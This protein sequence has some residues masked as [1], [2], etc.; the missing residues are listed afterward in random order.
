M[1]GAAMPMFGDD[2]AIPRRAEVVPR[3][4]RRGCEASLPIDRLLLPVIRSGVK[5]I[6]RIAA[7]AGGGK[8]TAIRHLR[9]VLPAGADVKLFD[10]HQLA[11]AQRAAC[12]GLA[13]F[14][15]S[16]P[17][18]DEK[19][20]D[21]FYLSP[22][23][24][25]DC[26]EYLHA[27][28][29]Q[30]CG[31]VLNRLC[32]EVSLATLAGLPQ[33]LCL[34][35]D[36]MCEDV[37]LGGAREILRQHIRRILPTGPALDR[38]IVDGP[39][40]APLT[41]DQ[42][43]WWQHRCVRNI[44]HAS[45]IVDKLVDGT[46]PNQLHLMD[47]SIDLVP[48]IAAALVDQRAAVE[49]LQRVVYE[50]RRSAALP[51]IASV[52]LAYDPG[53]KP[54]DGRGMIL[55]KAQLRGA[56]WAGVDLTGALLMGANFS[57][58]DLSGADLKLANGDLADF[59]G[60][61]LRGARLKKGRFLA[62]SFLS[63][64]LS[65]I[66]GANA[67]FTEVSFDHAKLAKADLREAKFLKTNFTY[68]SADH[69]NF[70]GASFSGVNLEGARFT[71]AT[72][73]SARFALTDFTE[74]ILD[75]ACFKN[76]RLV[77]C[78]FEW[79]EMNGVIFSEAMLNG[80]LLTGTRIIGGDFQHTN[81]CGTGLA[82]IIWE[83]ADLRGADLTNASFHMGSTRSGLVGSTIAGEGS[84]TGFYT[85]DFND[86]SFKPVEEIR[87]ACL[88]GANFLGAKVEGTDFY[89]V[90]LRQAIYSPKQAQ[91]FAKTGAILLG[92]EDAA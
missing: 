69:A 61:N 15:S 83:N 1:H 57:R 33:F 34:V 28:N 63:A 65:G 43:R 64:D 5:G 45:W 42:W 80:S 20:V 48:E 49:Y 37:I 84:R 7:P 9:A 11:D 67:D 74:S 21:V 38:L 62:A 13:V 59:S 71:S 89:L 6:V 91:H 29:P 17:V 25:D 52:L 72:F 10:A 14:A 70:K 47:D 51:M 12:G 75:A 54:D 39:S 73:S 77:S 46:I 90:D 36:R 16:D 18:M 86:Q 4:H 24:L 60:A 8:S 3:A 31:S 22:W 87:K 53:W 50:D 78:N 56:Q 44:C 27:K 32:G 40:F 76:A 88:R 2:G 85:D 66:S 23:T 79:L 92:N 41:P 68:V 58:A 35:M 26:M 30:L 82:E 19:F 81:L 55:T